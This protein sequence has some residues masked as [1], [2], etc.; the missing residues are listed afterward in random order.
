MLDRTRP[1]VRPLVGLLLAAALPAVAGEPALRVDGII[2]EDLWAQ[3]RSFDDFRVTQPYTQATPTHPTRALLLSLPEGLAVAFMVTQ[4]PGTARVKPRAGRDAGIEADRVNVAVDFDGDGRQAYNFMVTLGGAMGDES[5]TNE[6]R[7]NVDWDGVWD[8]AVHETDQGWSVEMLIPW[9]VAAMRENTGDTRTIGIYFDR[10]I[11][12]LN[13]RS[14]SPGTSFLQPRYVSAF[15]PVEIVQHPGQGRL[16]LIPYASLSNDLIDGRLSHR[17]GADLFW[18][19]S[20]KLQMS[21]TLNPDFGQVE[22]DD[23]VVDFSAIEVLFSDKRPFFTENQGVFDFRM[24][25]AGRLVYT[26]RIGG[27]SDVNGQAS[28]IDA[29]LKLS[30]H[31]G[32]FQLATLAAVESGYSDDIGRTFIAQRALKQ[33]GDL[34]LGWLTT[35]TDRPALERTAL[36]NALDVGWRASD[37]WSLSGQLLA[38]RILQDAPVSGFGGWLRATYV[39]TQWEQELELTRYGEGLDFNDLGYQRRGSFRELGAVT[40]RRIATFAPTDRRR[41]VTWQIE[42]RLRYND[43]GLRL[44]A[45]LTLRRTAALRAGG[46]HESELSWTGD[47]YD[48]RISR[49]QGP[50]WQRSRLDTLLHG[51]TS[52]RRGRWSWQWQAGLLN[53]GNEALAQ[54]FKAKLRYHPRDDLDMGLTVLPHWSRDWLLWREGTLFGSYRSRRQEAAMDLNWFPGRRHELRLKLQWLGLV[55]DQPVAYRLDAQGQLHRSQESVEAFTLSEFGMQLRYR[56]AWAQRR[57]LYVVYA[58]GGNESLFYEDQRRMPG[59]PTLLAD[60]TGLRDA[61]QLLVKL[62]WEL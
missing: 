37:R 29:A 5:I 7:F 54:Q 60:A 25:D 6:N 8:Y 52:P 3:A 32:D 28:D 51:Y 41:S 35:W 36:V 10:V 11:A 24:P 49:G 2:N 55:A 17:L 30:A 58:R 48:D 4:P 22:A 21:A 34:G 16:S 23:L 18:K 19:P 47:G 31:A 12:S 20:G 39:G 42:P 46:R 33:F 14:A 56:Y 45:E 43:E 61:D 44:P 50:V 57:E 15:T 59:L 1:G 40:T 38:S 26:R 62:R 27:P 53:T 13:E 9:T